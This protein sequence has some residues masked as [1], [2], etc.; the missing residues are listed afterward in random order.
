MV[1]PHNI[2][3]PAIIA[4]PLNPLAVLFSG[5][6]SRAEFI[7]SPGLPLGT[8]LGYMKLFII[9]VFLDKLIP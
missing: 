6:N 7:P 5:L 1:N 4:E 8:W 9:V 2:H 3:E